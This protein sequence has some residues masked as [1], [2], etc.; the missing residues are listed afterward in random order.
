[1]GLRMVSTPV[2]RTLPV[3]YELRQYHLSPYQTGRILATIVDT[4]CKPIY[5]TTLVWSLCFSRYAQNF[6]N[7]EFEVEENLGMMDGMMSHGS[8]EVLPSVHDL[9]R[10]I[11]SE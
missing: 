2:A 10:S 4:R 8:E 6:S 7:N 1:M 3:W 5:Q 9:C 11:S